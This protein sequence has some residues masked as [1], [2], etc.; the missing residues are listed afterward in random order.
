MQRPPSNS[1][2]CWRPCEDHLR[3]CGCGL[4]V[5]FIGSSQM[6]PLSA[7][8]ARAPLA[9]GM[10]GC[11]GWK[12]SAV[13]NSAVR[14]I[15]TVDVDSIYVR[16]N[17]TPTGDEVTCTFLW[18]TLSCSGRFTINSA[19]AARLGED[20]KPDHLEMV[21]C[22]STPSGKHYPLPS[23]LW[24]FTELNGEE[25]PECFRAVPFESSVSEDQLDDEAEWGRIA[26]EEEAYDEEVG[27]K[28]EA[29]E[30]YWEEKR[31]RTW[32]E[33]NAPNGEYWTAKEW[34]AAVEKFEASTRAKPEN[35][36]EVWGGVDTSHIAY[37]GIERYCDD[38]RAGSLEELM[39]FWGS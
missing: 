34:F 3:C 6:A 15:G 25:K 23:K 17:V 1:V 35:F 7:P 31:G 10:Y 4:A 14:S 30:A 12:W 19:E 18:D 9:Q 33:L 11:E 24:L 27:R 26:E 20:V 2:L 21:A 37:E 36:H 16:L 22:R 28:R 39:V 5:R 38:A 8:S 32:D 29:Q 13:T